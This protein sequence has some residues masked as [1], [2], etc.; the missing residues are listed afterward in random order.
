LINS[1]QTIV[2]FV[3]DTTTTTTTT[4][5]FA[6]ASIYEHVESVLEPATLCVTFDVEESFLPD[7]ALHIY[8]PSGFQSMSPTCHHEIHEVNLTLFPQCLGQPFVAMA[9][10]QASCEEIYDPRHL[11]YYLKLSVQGVSNATLGHAFQFQVKVPRVRPESNSWSVD[12]RYND[13]VPWIREHSCGM[14]HMWL[15]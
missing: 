15:A 7:P 8:L 11:R 13:R 1:Q 10:Q 4:W 14:G 5:N 9:S 3:A 12:L 6:Y 2:G